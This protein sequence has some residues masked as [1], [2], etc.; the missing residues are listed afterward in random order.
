MQ[1][2]FKFFKYGNK[3]IIVS[4]CIIS[5]GFIYTFMYHGGYNWGIDFSSGVS[6]NFVIDKAGIK[7]YEI[8]R[9]LS[10]VYKIFD[11]NE[12]ISS[13]ASKSH[14]S[15][16]VKSDITD[17]ALKKEI[18]STLVD[19]LHME[20]GVDIEILDSYFID[21]S[22]S[23]FLRAK[24][25]LLVFLTFTLIL[26]YVALRFRLSYAVSSIF[27]TI[28]DIL[29]VVAF[30]GVFRIEIN[31]SI[32]VSIL[33]IIGYSLNDT[34]I[35]FDRVREN[36]KSIPYTSFLNVLSVSIRQTLSR[37]ILTSITTFVVVLSIYVFTEG[38]IK[39]FALI[40]MVG[41]VVGTYSSIFIAST[42]LLS[43]NK[44]I[45]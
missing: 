15:I 2:V 3:V 23:S 24:S 32:I 38:A 27:A 42:I 7:D 30:L 5:L 33:T 19:R 14:F 43:F 11:V 9:L 16:I 41:V 22:F 18:Q 8:K 31:S 10:S 17:Y 25:I 12:I 39:D 36:S 20:F 13:D 37:T 1:R 35:I 4:F 34:I 6:I 44:K 28:H 45:K 21:S 26:I 29:F 40:F